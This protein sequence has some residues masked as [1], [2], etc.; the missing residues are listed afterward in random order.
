MSLLDGVKQ[1]KGTG[2]STPS[3]STDGGGGSLLNSVRSAR[4]ESVKP[5]TPSFEFDKVVIEPNQK[6]IDLKKI[7][8]SLIKTAKKSLPLIIR[9]FS[10]ALSK[11]KG[12]QL[13]RELQAKA[14]EPKKPKAVKEKEP[15]KFKLPKFNIEEFTKSFK[16]DAKTI[17]SPTQPKDLLIGFIGQFGGETKRVG[18]Q[19]FPS[20]EEK[21]IPQTRAGFIPKNDTQL[22]GAKINDFLAEITAMEAGGINEAFEGGVKAITATP[23]FQYITSTLQQ[24]ASKQ[25]RTMLNKIKPIKLTFEEANSVVR[26]VGTPEQIARFKLAEES[27]IPMKKIFA[28]TEKL[29]VNPKTKIYDFLKNTFDDI[30]KLLRSS[31]TKEEVKLLESG[32]K[33]A[34]SVIAKGEH[35]ASEVLN[36][37]LKAGIQKSKD[38]KNIIKLVSQATTEGKNIVVGSPEVAEGVSKLI[39]REIIKIDKIKG[40]KTA[41]AVIKGDTASLIIQIE[42]AFKS[43]GLGTKVLKM[44]EDKILEKGVTKVEIDASYTVS[45]GEYDN[46]IGF[47]EKQGFTETGERAFGVVKME[48]TLVGEARL[49]ENSNTGALTTA[50]KKA[51]AGIEGNRLNTTYQSAVD[52]LMRLSKE[53]GQPELFKKVMG[54]ISSRNLSQKEAVEFMSK[55]LKEM[56]DTGT[57][58][59]ISLIKPSTQQ[60]TKSPQITAD[61]PAGKGVTTQAQEGTPP[62]KIEDFGTLKKETVKDI[63]DVRST[64]TKVKKELERLTLEAEGKSIVAQE[65]REGLNTTDIATL[66]RVYASTPKFQEGDL[67]TIRASEKSGKLLNRVLENIQEKN[68]MMT[69]QEAFDFALELPT[70]K[71]AKG[72]TTP[73][74]RA[75]DKQSKTLSKY[76]DDLKTRQK[77]LEIKED[78]ALSKQWESVV[79]AQEELAKVIN[80]PRAQVPVGEG[81]LKVSRLEARIKNSLSTIP[82]DIKNENLGTFRQVNKASNIKK[83][84]EYVVS[85]PEGALDVLTG[86]IDAPEGVL[87]NSILI[88]M[89]NLDI[90]DLD[91]ATR[92]AS[93]MATRAGQELSILTEVN[94]N[95]PSNIL[96]DIIKV[97][98]EALE[99]RFAGKSAKSI[100]KSTVEKGKSMI[101]PPTKLNWDSIIEGIRC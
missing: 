62:P 4:G 56:R 16:K 20:K 53:S 87:R 98:T 80:V 27:G 28:N 86:K 70:Q 25:F 64:L 93:F 99:K 7:G 48:K 82:E 24:L 37:V 66:K 5:S 95:M 83:A 96:A 1:A 41:S 61:S 68:P 15:V 45:E 92:L 74:T 11:N 81:K 39:K 32:E 50:E 57:I 18:G 8:S 67:E 21:D 35:T 89:Q 60:P 42:D 30:A 54:E 84:T 26:G 51:L 52:E 33:I 49:F 29:K 75:L 58:A 47:W 14:K 73:D 6:K 31:L 79:S 12:V 101:K 100:V 63:K 72:G 23:K 34:E 71:T 2:T 9:G 19:N 78:D 13:G 94:K 85:D 40:V 44:L 10:Y 43:K 97:K 69:E 55:G 91:V 59:N 17:L 36:T 22:I 76:L 65:Q 3:Q 90:K 46:S 77:S 38:G 88:A